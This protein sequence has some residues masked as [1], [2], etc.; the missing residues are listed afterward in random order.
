[1]PF[2]NKLALLQ[3]YRDRIKAIREH[4]WNEET[5]ERLICQLICDLGNAVQFAMGTRDESTAVLE[6]VIAELEADLTNKVI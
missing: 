5:A 2:V 6:S 1:V 3:D 4:A